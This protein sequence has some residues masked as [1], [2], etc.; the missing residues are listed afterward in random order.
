MKRSYAKARAHKRFLH[1]AAVAFA[2]GTNTLP[3][4]AEDSGAAD[5]RAATAHGANAANDRYRHEFALTPIPGEDQISAQLTV[6]PLTSADAFSIDLSG[7]CC[8][9]PLQAGPHAVRVTQGQ[10]VENHLLRVDRG[11]GDYLHFTA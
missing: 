9:G 5:E 3:A 11:T 4:R 7:S 10:R 8:I 6:I 1:L 2:L